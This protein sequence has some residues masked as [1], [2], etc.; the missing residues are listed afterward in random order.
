MG[1][2]NPG[3]NILAIYCVSAEVSFAT[4]KAGLNL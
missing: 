2:Y 4:I 3:Q 1:F